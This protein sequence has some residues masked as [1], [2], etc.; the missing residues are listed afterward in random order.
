MAG[1]SASGGP[2]GESPHCG[3]AGRAVEPQCGPPGRGRRNGTLDP[4][5]GA[6][7]GSRGSAGASPTLRRER[8]TSVGTA[9]GAVRTSPDGELTARAPGR[10]LSVADRPHAPRRRTTSEDLPD[11]PGPDAGGCHP[12]PCPGRRRGAPPGR[13]QAGGHAAQTPPPQQPSVA[14]RQDATPTTPAAAPTAAA[15]AG[16]RSWLGPVAGLAAGL[17]LAALFSH[18]GLGEGLAQVVTLLLLAVV[19]FVVIRWLM[20]RLGAGPARSR[21]GADGLQYAGAG[22]PFTP[23]RDPAPATPRRCSA[24]R[25]G[26]HRRCGC[27]PEAGGRRAARL[28]RGRVRAHRQDDLHPPAGR[29]RHRRGGG[30]AP[31]HDAR[32]VRLAAGGP[33]GAR[34][35]RAADRRGQLRPRCWTPR[36][37]TASGSSACAST[38]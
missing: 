1:P 20:R 31:L 26:S 35:R 5:G 10:S 9:V 15:P 34:R 33:A 27:R 6:W 13:R 29:E 37:R 14:P 16:K 18:F 3:V 4:M 36:R 38:A 11:R 2:G 21:A 12:E 7:G 30:P 24:A 32:A 23:P 17:G 25:R 22:A 8:L 19:A 28:R